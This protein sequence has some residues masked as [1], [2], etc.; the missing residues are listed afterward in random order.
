MLGHLLAFKQF[1]GENSNN[2]KVH[3]SG[4][5]SIPSC[6]LS[7]QWEIST[8][9]TSFSVVAANMTCP[10]SE[11]RFLVWIPASSGDKELVPLALYSLDGENTQYEPSFQ[12]GF[13][14]FPSYLSGLS[15]GGILNA[16]RHPGPWTLM[17]VSVAHVTCCQ[18]SPT[19]SA[20]SEQFKRR[21]VICNFSRV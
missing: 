21:V 5:T 18:M 20:T 12:E 16:W 14:D 1:A 10:M 13:P 9:L 17:L 3:V 7:A 2:V 19:Q 4:N 8:R 15:L 11:Q 6:L